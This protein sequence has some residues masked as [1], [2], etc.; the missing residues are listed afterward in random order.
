MVEAVGLGLAAG[1][2]DCFYCWL[3]DWWFEGW[4]QEG[5]GCGW[6]GLRFCR[7]VGKVVYY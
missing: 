5:E 2:V 4:G 1:E 7:R 3:G 6:Y